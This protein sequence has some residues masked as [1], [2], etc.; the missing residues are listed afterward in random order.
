M[1]NKNNYLLFSPLMFAKTFK[2]YYVGL[3]KGVVW[4]YT[5]QKA[6]LAIFI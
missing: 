4:M 6:L 3:I 1:Q 2:L 5:V